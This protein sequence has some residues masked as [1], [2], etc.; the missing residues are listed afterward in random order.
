[1]S[2]NWSRL[3]RGLGCGRGPEVVVALAKPFATM[4]P[5]LADG[6]AGVVGTVD[7]SACSKGTKISQ[8]GLESYI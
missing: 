6:A 2:F 3:S 5:L 1:M 4:L 7:I 8:T